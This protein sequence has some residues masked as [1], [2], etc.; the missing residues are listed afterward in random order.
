MNNVKI[1]ITEVELPLVVNAIN[2]KTPVIK[3]GNRFF[4]YHQ[5]TTILPKKEADFMEKM[6]LQE[7]GMY[8][9]KKYGVI[10][11]LGV[12]CT[13]KET[14]EIDPRIQELLESNP[15]SDNLLQSKN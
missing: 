8:R 9:C 15:Q 5:F 11:K 6:R 1:D 2:A 10:H 3:I 13:C 4:A 12:N 14:G 7:K